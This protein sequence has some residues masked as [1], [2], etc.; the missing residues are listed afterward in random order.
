MSKGRSSMRAW[1]S[2]TCTPARAAS[3]RAPPPPTP[4]RQHLGLDV[5][6]HAGFHIRSETDSQ[7][8]RPAANVDQPFGALQA[9]PPRH[10]AKKAG[11]I[12]LAVS[13]VIGNGRIETA[14]EEF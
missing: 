9:L 6:P 3:P 8:S 11:V 7:R 10:L 4:G 5:H 14:H 13:G 1:I 12:R 2:S